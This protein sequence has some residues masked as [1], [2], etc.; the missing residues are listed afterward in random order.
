[1]YTPPVRFTTLPCPHC[2]ARVYHPRWA[3]IEHN[4]Y[5][6]LC[7]PCYD[8][9]DQNFTVDCCIA[10]ARAIVRRSAVML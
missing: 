10:E 2:A 5:E 6:C 8:A 9:L 4:R 1:M 7:W 3:R